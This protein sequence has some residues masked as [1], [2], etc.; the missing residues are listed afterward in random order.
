MEQAGARSERRTGSSLSVVSRLWILTGA[1]LLSVLSL[2]ASAWYASAEQAAAMRQ[3]TSISAG[4]DRQWNADM[5]HDALRADVM[6]ALYATT[7][8]QRELYAVDEVTDHGDA[9]ITNF[10][11]AASYAPAS[12]TERFSATRPAV[13]EYAR[14]AADLVAT[15][16]TDRSAAIARLDGFLTLYSQLEENLGG[17]DEDMAAAVAAAGANG[18]TATRVSR[19]IITLA[20]AALV[21]V[22]LIVGISTRRVI[23]P[24]LRH[25]L[26]GLQKVA[27]Y[28]LDVQVPVLRRDELG[29][30]AGA[31]NHAVAAVRETVAATAT[32]IE[33]L[34]RT[35]TDM[36]AFA[37]ELDQSAERTSQEAGQAGAAAH[38]A[39][40]AAD[41]MT[42]AT[43]TIAGSV[44]DI[45]RQAGA[46]TTITGQAAANAEHTAATVTSLSQASGEIGE[47]VA[48][49]SSIAEQTNLLALNATIEAARAGE[50]GKGFAVVATEVK[51][52]A[53]ETARATA[54]ITAKITNIQQMAT[55][56]ATAITAITDV[57][58]DI[59]AS[60]REIASAV[61]QQAATT[62]QMN[63]QANDMTDATNQIGTTLATIADSARTTAR[64]AAATRKSAEQISAATSDI[65]T[66]ISRFR[67]VRPGS[68]ARTPDRWSVSNH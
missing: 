29:T 17:L 53:Q 52:L 42:R 33:T 61:D 8:R 58:A 57:I 3:I 19:Q 65:H 22:I 48:L 34:S 60:Q 15:A 27:G 46:A 45:A 63:G 41:Q 67:Y 2:A 12:L 24:P 5:M 23:R 44:S 1:G 40:S 6:A 68:D 31:L 51:D 56:T 55:D 62:G 43:E 21:A 49:I 13:Q 30:M 4:M 54:D 14:S 18:A 50:A 20:A 59:D 32:G 25:M 38:T 36:R 11:A 16:G 64:S 39:Q 26:A 10:D 28:D 35:S 7:E 47:V 66:L 9:M 37:A